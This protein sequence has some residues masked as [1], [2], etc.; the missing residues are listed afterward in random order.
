MRLLL[1]LGLG[2]VGLTAAG[3]LLGLPLDMDA[4]DLPRVQILVALMMAA[5]ALY[6]LAVRVVL[7]G[8]WPRWTVWMVLAVAVVLRALPLSVPPFLSSDIYRYVWDGRVQAAGIN[9]YR[10]VPR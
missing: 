3:L 6:F 9:P 4:A 1:F 10:H 8:T 5:A 7:R 2:L